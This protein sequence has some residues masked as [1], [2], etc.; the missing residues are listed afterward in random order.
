MDKLFLLIYVIA[1]VKPRLFLMLM[2]TM[3]SLKI[4]KKLSMEDVLSVKG[5]VR[6]ENGIGSKSESINR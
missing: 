6:P 5:L 3:V 2:I 4:V 1:M